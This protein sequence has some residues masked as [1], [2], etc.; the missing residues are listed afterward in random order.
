[1]AIVI[2]LSVTV[3]ACV[4]AAWSITWRVRYIRRILIVMASSTMPMCHSC[5]WLQQNSYGNSKKKDGYCYF[6][7]HSGSHCS[8]ILCVSHLL[9]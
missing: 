4:I 3:M 2:S 9:P 1:M 7:F 5:R 8:S 6:V